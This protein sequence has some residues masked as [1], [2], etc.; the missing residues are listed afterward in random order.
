M[1]FLTLNKVSSTITKW[2]G[3]SLFRTGLGLRN[4]IISPTTSERRPNSSYWI[5]LLCLLP[6][7]Q[8]LLSL[9]I[10][11]ESKIRTTSYIVDKQKQDSEVSTTSSRLINPKQLSKIR[12]NVYD[13][14][15]R[16]TIIPHN[17]WQSDVEDSWRYNTRLV[18]WLRKEFLISKYGPYI[19]DSLLAYPQLKLSPQL[20]T[21]TSRRFLL[22][23]MNRG[24]IDID[25]ILGKKD[26][27]VEGTLMQNHHDYHVN[28]AY[29]QLP[30]ADVVVKA[31]KMRD[32][33]TTKDTQK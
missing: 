18:A 21:P 26:T 29:L 30:T 2:I 9:A 24:I 4:K 28:N 3:P 10:Y 16:P 11:E 25:S 14:I 22:N 7:S 15:V 5:D 32:W 33:A 6:Y 27:V 31:F 12:L 23:L 13:E 20:Q 17:S 1:V 19:Q 8:R